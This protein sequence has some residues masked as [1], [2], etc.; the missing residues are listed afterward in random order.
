MT[1]KIK[2]N[3]AS[4]GGSF[5]L[6]APSSSSNNRVLT[7]PDSADGT[8]AK[9][10]DINYVKL[11][12]LQSSDPV[13]S[14]TFSS[15]DVTTY[16]TFK[17]I[18]TG[19]PTTDATSL[20]FRFMVDGTGQAENQYHW[21][22]LG[23]TNAGAVFDSALQQTAGRIA[24]GAGSDDQEGW[25]FELTVLPHVSGDPTFRNNFAYSQNVRFNSSNLYR[26]ESFWLRYKT[27]VATNGFKIYADSGNIDNYSYTL[28]GLT[29]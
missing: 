19:I 28:Y 4:G 22:N 5:S 15:L 11:Q 17:L 18:F 29:R 10:S 14:I 6:Q 12:A 3:A 21:G 13:S 9:T 2:L 7:L 27:N 8:I 25:T 1:A 26:G 20:A 24:G 23:V 16:R